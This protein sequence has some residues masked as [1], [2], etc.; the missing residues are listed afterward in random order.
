MSDLPSEIS[1]ALSGADVALGRLDGAL[2]QLGD[3]DLHRAHRGGGW[4]VAQVI[5]HVNMATIC[6]A[7][8]TTPSWSSS[9]ARRSGTT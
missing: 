2:A 5:S 4:S 7:S 1:E 3:G 8:S 9:S 6:A